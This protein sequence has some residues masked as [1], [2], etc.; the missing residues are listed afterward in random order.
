MRGA[1]T[2]ISVSCQCWARGW[3]HQSFA[4]VVPVPSL[5]QLCQPW[6]LMPAGQNPRDA[7]RDP[8]APVVV[9]LLSL[10]QSLS[11][12]LEAILRSLSLRKDWFE[13]S[14]EI[15]QEMLF[16]RDTYLSQK[17]QNP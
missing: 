4:A 3:I 14:V 1:I 11:M 7:P 16:V 5:C 8:P 15:P 13:K 17:W 12:F 9:L 2:P 10:L 6:A